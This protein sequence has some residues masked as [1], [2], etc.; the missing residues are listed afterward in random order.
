MEHENGQGKKALPAAGSHDKDDG[1]VRLLVL[2]LTHPLSEQICF[3][4]I[5]GKGLGQS[6]LTH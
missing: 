5:Q 1:Q 4:F 3:F 2:F 6:T